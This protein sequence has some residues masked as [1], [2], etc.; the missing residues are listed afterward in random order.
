MDYKFNL[1]GKTYNIKIE[2]DKEDYLVSL[3]GKKQL[4]VKAITSVSNCLSLVV[5]GKATILYTA[6]DKG[7]GYIFVDG[8]YFMLELEKKRKQAGLKVREIAKEKLQFLLLCRAL[9]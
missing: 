5:D 4:Q 6:V 9:L 7:K 8:N 1:E 2:R 3:D